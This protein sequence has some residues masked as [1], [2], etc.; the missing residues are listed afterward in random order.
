MHNVLKKKHG[1]KE[2]KKLL[3]NAQKRFLGG[4]KSGF[5]FGTEQLSPVMMG[6]GPPFENLIF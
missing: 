2:G 5:F 3:K 4:Q 1:K 6:G